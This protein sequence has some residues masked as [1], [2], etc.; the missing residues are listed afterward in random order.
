V[1]FQEQRKP[2][3]Q[4]AKEFFIALIGNIRN[5]GKVSRP[6][7]FSSIMAKNKWS[8]K[9]KRHARLNVNVEP[10]GKV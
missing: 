10:V 5:V 3:I 1:L 8:I 4:L 7:F 2:S 6:D 9:R